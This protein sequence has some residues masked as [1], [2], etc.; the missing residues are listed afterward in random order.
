V[1]TPEPAALPYGVPASAGPA[2]ASVS[3]LESSPVP[4][5]LVAIWKFGFAILCCQNF[6]LS[7]LLLGWSYRFMQRTALMAWWK[8]NGSGSTF[9]EFAA[10][11]EDTRPHVY[12]PNW[13]L[14]QNF[15]TAFKARTWRALLGSLWLNIR[16]GVTGAFNTFV[17]TLPGCLLMLFGWYDGWNNSFNKGYEQFGVGPGVSWIGILM[18]ATAMLY[19]PM[20]QAR[21]AVSGE[22][23]AFYQWRMIWRL[24]RLR[25]LSCLGISA[26]YL[27]LWAPIMILRATPTFWPQIRKLNT[28]QLAALSHAEAIKHL[29]AYY[30]WCA[31]L[32]IP[33]FLF[34]RWL[35]ARNYAAGITNAIKCGS[36]GAYA[37][38]D[39]ERGALGRLNL[40]EVT[41]PPE[42]H[43]LLRLAARL[44]R[45]TMRSAA[46]AAMLLVWILFL[47]ELYVSQFFNH[48]PGMG[49]LNHCLVQLPWFH[50]VPAHLTK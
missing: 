14:D 32:V 38:S 48:I 39:F 18:F 12:W 4:R 2:P 15:R 25:W 46:V 34:L 40:L 16:T 33:A 26:I 3:S 10:A 49:W 7:F 35:A 44:W 22:W 5:S 31:L 9:G 50:Y 36:I 19:V 21:Q 47:F 6:L 13:F 11:D 17:L 45:F 20:A 29:N 37:L 27:L 1:S 23:R 43:V 30:L 42:R 41:L 24:V 28:D 8:K